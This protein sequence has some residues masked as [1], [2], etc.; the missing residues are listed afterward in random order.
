MASC[1]ERHRD[2]RL[3]LRRLRE[4]CGLTQEA[5]AER[6]GTTRQTLVAWESG[7]RRPSVVNLWQLAVVYRVPLTTLVRG[8]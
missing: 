5:V 7:A 6:I 8:L 3:S 1:C 4:L 2:V